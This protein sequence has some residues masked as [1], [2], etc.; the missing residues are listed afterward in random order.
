MNKIKPDAQITQGLPADNTKESPEMKRWEALSGFGLDRPSGS[1]ERD[2]SDDKKVL[3]QRGMRIREAV[4][5]KD[6]GEGVIQF[7]ACTDGVKRDGNRVRND[8]WSFANFE[9]NPQFLWCH[10]YHSL[11]IG[12][13][14]QWEIGKDNGESVLRLW[15]QFCSADLYPFADKVRQMYEGGFL[16]AGSVGWIPLE[17]EPLKDEEDRTIGFD[18]TRNEL[19]EFSAVPVPSDPDAIVEAVQRGVVS[20]DD[21]STFMRSG[22][23]AP[24]EDGLFYTLSNR[25]AE[26]E[27]TVAREVAEVEGVEET[28]EEVVDELLVDELLEDVEVREVESLEGEGSEEL[29]SE[30]PCPEAECCDEEQEDCPEPCCEEER[31]ADVEGDT[32][33]EALEAPVEI[34][35]EERGGLD[36]EEEDDGSNEKIYDKAEKLVSTIQEASNKFADS[37]IAA[38]MTA[39]AEDHSEE[40]SVESEIAESRDS[41]ETEAE[42]EAETEDAVV[43][44]DADPEMVD[45]E[46]IEEVLTQSLAEGVANARVG[47]KVSKRTK[48]RLCRC[49]DMLVEVTDSISDLMDEEKAEYKEDDDDMTKEVKVPEASSFEESDSENG[50]IAEEADVEIREEAQ[51]VEEDNA[52]RL[53]QKIRGLQEDLGIINQED[54]EDDSNANPIDDIAQRIA[55]VS[56]EINSSIGEKENVVNAEEPKS[57]YVRSILARIKEME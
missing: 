49:R 18:F 35:A 42:A 1:L 57:D 12:K 2:L 32:E 41:A 20:S 25:D 11:P 51:E 28:S 23:M 17:W 9:K 34:D 36:S 43:A 40:A 56:E 33:I 31:S 5:E 10:E 24:H 14:V 50:A 15:S 30:D 13:H 26:V 3:L 29:G 16:R 22:L 44:L 27:P 55:A 39:L 47:A 7:I 38:V 37:V 45:P 53:L 21:I 46:L 6:M 4:V 8:G 48:D 52:S 19:L 54:A